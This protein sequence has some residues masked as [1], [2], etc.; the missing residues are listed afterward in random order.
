MGCTRSPFSGG[1]QCC[2]F[3]TGPVNPDVIRLRQCLM[4]SIRQISIRDLAA[5]TVLVAVWFAAYGLAPNLALLSV[6]AATLVMFAVLSSTLWPFL[7]LPFAVSAN[8]AALAYCFGWWTSPSDAVLLS[9]AVIVST[10]AISIFTIWRTRFRHAKTQSRTGVMFTAIRNSVGFGLCAGLQLGIPVCI[11]G[12][13]TR[14]P[15]PAISAQHV[16]QQLL[17]SYLIGGLL[18]GIIL[19]VILAFVCDT[20]VAVDFRKHPKVSPYQAAQNAG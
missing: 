16:L 20:I 18:L 14:S 1:L 19:G 9:G 11:Y 15:F 8:W 13:A 10:I 12:V 17:G 2:A 3:C 6:G 7:A 5:A 4:E